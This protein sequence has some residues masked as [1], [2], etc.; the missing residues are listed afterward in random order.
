MAESLAEI[1]RNKQ[2]QLTEA[3][4]LVV[5]L[6]AELQEAKEALLGTALPSPARPPETSTDMA[7]AVLRNA[8]HDLHINQILSTIESAF[9][10]TVKYA[11]LVTNIS[12]LVQKKKTFTRTGPNRFGLMEWD[13]ERE[14]AELF[15]REIR[16]QEARD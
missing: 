16:E 4:L 5:R 13:V 3:E 9:H 1:I 8:G 7:A 11:T 6:R 2:R 14:A 10:V 15:G 12:R